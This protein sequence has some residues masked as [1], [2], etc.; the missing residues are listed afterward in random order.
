MIVPSIDISDGR[1]VQLRRGRELVLEGGDPLERLA[2]YS[3]AGEVAVIDLDGA[4]GTGSNAELIREMVRRAPCRVGGGIRTVDGALD[5]LDAGAARIIVGTAASVEFCAQLPRHRVIAAVDAEHGEVVVEGWETA[6]GV[7]V[8]DRIKELAPVVGG[9]LFTQVEHEGAMAGFDWQLIEA[10]VAAG[11]DARVTAAGG[12]TNA[13]EIARLHGLGADAQVGMALYSGALS[14]GEAVAAPLTKPID[15][16]RWPTVVVDESGAALG[17]VWSTAE[18]VAAA[19]AT[20][21]GVYWSRSR[22][23]LWEK[24]ATSGATQELLRVDLDCDADALRFTVHQHG[25]GFCHKRTRGCWETLFSLHS[26][27]RVIAERATNPEPGSNTAALLGEPDL[28][29]AKITE[30]AAEL[31]AAAGQEDIVREAAD[32]LYFTIARLR[33]AGA[34]LA[35]VEDEL[36]RRHGRVRRRPMTTK[37]PT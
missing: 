20:R 4:R 32:L 25:L 3:V 33:A 18:S 36:R 1:A 35:A 16:D 7:P 22:N 11:G 2:E 19:V 14:L 24:G 29:A 21:T 10:A 23:E 30:E 28:L 17:L 31:N 27:D 5:W 9:F 34:T 12:I 37:E 6:T 15:G 26:L 13:D 8:L